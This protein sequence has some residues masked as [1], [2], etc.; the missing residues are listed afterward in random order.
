ML[1]LCPITVFGCPAC[2]CHC[3][4]SSW[5]CH[6]PGSSLRWLWRR[7]DPLNQQSSGSRC[8]LSDKTSLPH[9]FPPLWARCVRFSQVQGKLTEVKEV[10]HL[11]F[12]ESLHMKFIPWKSTESKCTIWSPP[13]GWNA[14]GSLPT[15]TCAPRPRGGRL[16]AL[17]SSAE[18]WGPH[19]WGSLGRNCY[20]LKAHALTQSQYCCSFLSSACKSWPLEVTKWHRWQ[21]TST[22]IS[23]METWPRL[24]SGLLCLEPARLW[25][26]LTTYCIRTAFPGASSLVS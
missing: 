21:G 22:C 4:D 6:F 15:G 17:L 5:L 13:D 23:C 1:R 9:S 18:C 26:V 2:H 12:L 16:Q 7:D 3:P 24:G 10:G 11:S 20:V 19:G 25:F 8:L 14:A